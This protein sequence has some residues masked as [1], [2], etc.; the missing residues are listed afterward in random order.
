MAIPKVYFQNIK[1]NYSGA[2]YTSGALLD[3]LSEYNIAC[4]SFPFKYYPDA[5]DAFTTDWKD[6]NGV[7]VY[8][9]TEAKKKD[10][11][12]EAEFI[13]KGAKG[14][15]QQNVKAFIEKLYGGGTLISSR[16]AVYDEHTGLGFKDVRV[17]SVDPDAYL[18][19]D[20]DDEVVIT[21]KIKFHVYDPV[22]KVTLHYTGGV[23]DALTW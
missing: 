17:V 3:P 14:T 18:N 5:K 19:D 13:A 7:D 8:L 15:T 9:P 16:W 12:L 10:Y 20:S 6:E 4:Q 22:T 2:T 11:E 1:L 23:V 21:F